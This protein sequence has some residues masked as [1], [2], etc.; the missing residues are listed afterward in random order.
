MMPA[1]FRWF[2]VTLCNSMFAYEW[3]PCAF[4]VFALSQAA[5]VSEAVGRSGDSLC[6]IVSVEN[7]P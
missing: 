2:T 3:G 7:D 4:R 1:R 6:Q 5:A